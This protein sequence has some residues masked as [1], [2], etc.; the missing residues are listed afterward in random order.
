MIIRPESS[1]DLDGIRQVNI[2]AFRDH[3]HSQQTE[4]LIV[5]ALRE[6]E[7]LEVSFVAESSGEVIGHIAFSAAEIGAPS[8]G[9]R[10]LGP[11][12]VLPERQGEGVGRALMEAGLAE[13]RARGAAGVVLVGDP[14]FYQRFGFTHCPGVTC[15]GVPDEYVLCL[16]LS[17]EA[18]AG[19]V[20][21]HPAFL[22]GAEA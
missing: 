21:H 18:P 15:H 8:E 19:E 3:P 17:G 14:A 5:D 6:A 16:T 9:W 20:T 10:L 1:E 22:T 11:V 7:A 12:A 2:A 13:M 4:H